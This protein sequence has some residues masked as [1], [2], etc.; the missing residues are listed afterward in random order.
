MEKSF[1]HTKTYRYYVHGDPQKAKYLLYVLHGYGQLAEYFLRKFHFL[2]EDFLIVAPEGMHRFYLQGNS[3][4]VGASWMTKEARE[5]DITDNMDWLSALDNKIRSEFHFEKKIILGFSQGGATAA[6]WVNQDKSFDVTILWACIFPPDLSINSEI[7][8]N[9]HVKHFVLG[10]EDEYFSSQQQCE[11]IDFYKKIGY[12]TH[13][14]KGK[15]N[16]DADTLEKI[17]QS[18]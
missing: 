13:T 15:H 11:A 7:K 5:T 12:N 17:L 16:I 4:R 14:F 9:S 1:S 10:T 3:G 18:L 2:P 8:T 6:R